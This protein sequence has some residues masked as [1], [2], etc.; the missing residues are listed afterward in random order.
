MFLL[1]VDDPIVIDSTTKSAAVDHDITLEITSFLTAYPLVT[2]TLPAIV[3]FVCRSEAVLELTE[4]TLEEP[5]VTY[6]TSSQE[7][8]L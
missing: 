1:M 5:S 3:K 2:Y 8:S 7:E 4:T 6:D